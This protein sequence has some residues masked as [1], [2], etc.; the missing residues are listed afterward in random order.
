MKVAFVP[1]DSQIHDNN[2]FIPNKINITP[3]IISAF[4]P[5]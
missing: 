1:W 3:P 4:F 5:Y 2:I